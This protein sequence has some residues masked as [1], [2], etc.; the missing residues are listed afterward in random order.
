M[1]LP[2]RGS[3]FG[4]DWRS[5]IPLAGFD[6]GLDSGLA[7]GLAGT[8]PDIDVYRI[9][10]LNDRP[11]G[12]AVNRGFV[13]DDGIRLGWGDEVAFDMTRGDRIGYL[14]GPRWT[15]AL[16][17][18]FYS[19]VA[20][21]TAAWRGLLP[22]HACAVE[23]DGRAVLIAGAGG[24]GKSTL[25]AGLLASGAR[26]VADDLVVVRVGEGRVAGRNIVTRGRPTIRLH[27]D[28]ASALDTIHAWPVPGDPR[29]KWLARPRARSNAFELNLSA[30]LILGDGIAEGAAP[31]Q[32]AVLRLFP[33]LFRRAWID[34]L[35]MRGDLMRDLLRLSVRVPVLGYPAQDGVTPACRQRRAAA[36]IGLVRDRLGSRR[37]SPGAPQV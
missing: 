5:D 1:D 34:A 20:A 24:A 11:G 32:G 27:P 29:G 18:T 22:L 37:I 21:L 35:P 19:T 16:P 10:A 4:L 17:A 2:Y 8:A 30:I 15:G 9:D 7:P 6:S 12:R 25:T 13:Y 26:F 28:T 31:A 3:A 36:A 23:L 14:P 33:H